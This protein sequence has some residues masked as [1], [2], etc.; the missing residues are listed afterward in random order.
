MISHDILEHNTTATSQEL[1]VQLLLHYLFLISIAF[2]QRRY[3]FKFV[4]ELSQLSY[5]VLACLVIAY[6]LHDHQS[7]VASISTHFQCISYPVD[8]R[9]RLVETD[10]QFAAGIT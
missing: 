2:H 1:H 8:G 10:H 4:V 6:H 5:L 7:V 3:E 9:R